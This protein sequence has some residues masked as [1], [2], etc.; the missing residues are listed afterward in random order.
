MHGD[1]HIS[2]VAL[3]VERQN[4]SAYIFDA[5]VTKQNVAGRDLAVLEVSAI[6]Y[7]RFDLNTVVQLCGAIYGDCYEMPDEGSVA[8]VEPVSRCRVEFV[9]GLRESA[10]SWNEPEV[11][12]LMVLDFALIQLQ[13]LAFGS[14]GNRIWDQRSAAYLLGVVTRWYEKHHK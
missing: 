13:G 9:R 2:N 12:A 4:V 1:L 7:Q 11:Y 8:V 14:S 10:K 6:L 5:G 3:D